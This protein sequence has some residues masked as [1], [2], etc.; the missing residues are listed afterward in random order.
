MRKIFSYANIIATLALVA[1]LSGSAYAASVLV[2]SSSQLGKGVVTNS[3]VKKATLKANRLTPAARTQFTGD[4][5]YGSV[6]MVG[7]AYDTKNV[8]HVDESDDFTALYC[9]ETAA[10][11]K[12]VVVTLLGGGFAMAP[13]VGY[14][15]TDGCSAATDFYVRTVNADGNL[16]PDGFTFAAN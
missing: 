4:K 2:K 15:T 10:P 12:N 6:T 16:Q 8:V 14:G 11:V 9:V 1:A 7:I 5:V 3:K 13:K